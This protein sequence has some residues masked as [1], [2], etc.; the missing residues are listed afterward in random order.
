MIPVF[1]TRYAAETFGNCF[2]ACIA[3]ILELP[4]GAI[5]DRAALVDADAWADLVSRA[6]LAGGEQA[7]GDLDL[8]PEY[9]EGED[10]LRAW[11]ADRGIGWLDLNVG[12][13]RRDV[14]E[15]DW[16]TL[17]GAGFATLYWIAHTRAA[18][19]STSH[20][21]VWRGGQL[22]HNPHRGWPEGKPLG[23]LHAATLLIA[24]NPALLARTLD[25]LP[26]VA[27]LLE[28]AAA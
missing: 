8:P 9:D 27:G 1:Q 10:R 16:L 11:L 28:E 22:E 7:V 20:A 15:D 21:T 13:G 26:D 6:R 5:P 23:P 18:P 24:G 19:T 2:E 17:T 25:P 3:S 14:R 12:E 4:L